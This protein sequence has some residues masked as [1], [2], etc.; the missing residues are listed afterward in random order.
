MTMW[1][2]SNLHAARHLYQRE[3]FQLMSET[4]HISFGYDLVAQVWERDL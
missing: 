2:Q 1:T 4:P 3:G